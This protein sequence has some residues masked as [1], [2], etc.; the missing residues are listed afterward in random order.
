[1]NDNVFVWLNDP[2]NWAGTRFTAGIV[3][4]IVAHLWYTVI[5]LVIAFVIGF[6]LGLVLGHSGR[7]GWL[8]RWPT[9]SARCPRWAC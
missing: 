9:G 5:G 2:Q 4:Q 3:D 6:P 7:A 8:C 1:M